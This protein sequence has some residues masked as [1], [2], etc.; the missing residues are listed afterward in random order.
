MLDP[1]P[2][3][4]YYLLVSREE[5]APYCRVWPGYFD[6]PLPII[7][8]P[9][10]KPDPDIPLRLQALIETIYEQGRYGE[11]IDYARPL[12]PPLTAQQAAW[13]KKQLRPQPGSKPPT[14]R[15]RRDRRR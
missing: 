7:P 14:T 1:L 12:D 5:K 9:L 8:I 11:E 3:S 6:Q 13:L 2:P 15:P 10:R 4:P